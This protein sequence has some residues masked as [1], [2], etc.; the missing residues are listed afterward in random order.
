MREV[1]RLTGPADVVLS[2][3]FRDH[4]RL[5]G[6]ERGMIAEATYAL[7]RRRDLYNHLS[8]SGSGPQMRRRAL[9]GLSEAA[10]MDAHSGLADA[11]RA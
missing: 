3:Y 6:R 2:R 5:G 1:L 10:G 9:L 11:E 4:P 8:E 7:L